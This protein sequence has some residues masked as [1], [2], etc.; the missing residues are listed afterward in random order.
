[1]QKSHNLIQIP[2][3]I[4]NMPDVELLCGFDPH[5]MDFLHFLPWNFYPRNCQPLVYLV[6]KISQHSH[7]RLSNIPRHSIVFKGI[8][9]HHE[10]IP[11]LIEGSKQKIQDEEDEWEKSSDIRKQIVQLTI[12]PFIFSLKCWLLNLNSYIMRWADGDC[13]KLIVFNVFSFLF[14]DVLIRPDTFVGL[15]LVTCQ[16]DRASSSHLI[17]KSD[18]HIPFHRIDDWNDFFRAKNFINE[19]NPDFE[20]VIT[21]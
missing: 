9:S 18:K 10:F 11:I 19:K 2:Q 20:V 7:I 4:D 5:F 14:N 12:V 8:F 3:F 13:G 15:Y 6:F 16:C 1:M 17:R 21:I